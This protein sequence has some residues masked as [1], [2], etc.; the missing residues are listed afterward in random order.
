[1]M[2]K[3]DKGATTSSALRDKS[4]ALI[5][6]ALI[7]DVR[8]GRFVVDEPLPA[9]R[10]LC[11]RFGS[12]R[13][14]VREALLQVEARGYALRTSGHRPRAAIPSVEGIFSAT[15]GQFRELLG[16]V[17]AGFHIEQVRQFIEVGA[18]V[19]ASKDTSATRLAQIHA[20][21]LRC[22]EAIGDESVSIDADI[23][24]HRA[25]VEAV[26]NPIILSLHD[27]FVRT[28]LTS[29][30]PLADRLAHDR[31]I[32]EEHREIYEALA[33]HDVARAVAVMDKHLT[34]SSRSRL[35]TP[36]HANTTSTPT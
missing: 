3:A 30:P 4:A 12:S 15:V 17:A 18:V 2:V 16:D 1:M 26:G 34:R 21:L 33:A 19:A 25:I 31:V 5:V 7:A 23:A 10:Q 14:T 6:E 13:P 28:M 22:H 29:R 20:A 24:F 11:E 27:R 32:Y 8:A 9:E 36:P 35:A